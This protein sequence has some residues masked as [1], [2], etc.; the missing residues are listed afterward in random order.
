MASIEQMVNK[1]N[2]SIAQTADNLNGFYRKTLNQNNQED[3]SNIINNLDSTT[4]SIKDA[5][6]NKTIKDI[7]TALALNTTIQKLNSGNGTAAKLLNDPAVYTAI[8]KYY[9]KR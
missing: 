8:T 4:K 3:L 7:Q 2:G 5:D 9:Q 1:Q 6:L